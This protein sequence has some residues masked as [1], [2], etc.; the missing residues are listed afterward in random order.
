MVTDPDAGLGSG[1]CRVQVA[2]PTTRVDLALPTSV[3]VA[4]LLPAIVGYAEQDLAA[5]QG[6]ALSRL[7]GTRLDPAG[8]LAIA[9]IQEGE[10]LLLHAAHD[11]VGQPLY[12]DVVEVLSRTAPESGW[13]SRDTRLIGAGLGSLAVAGAVWAGITT[14]TRLAGILL[15]VLALLLLGAG[16]LLAHGTGDRG[17]GVTLA[18]LAALIGPVGGVLILGQPFGPAHLLVAAALLVFHAAITPPLIGGGDAVC[19]ALGLLGLLVILGGLLV[20][21][22]PATP[23]RAAAVVAPLAL[24]LTTVMPTLALRLSRI[25]RP[26]LP[27]TVAELAEVPGQL[28]LEQIQ[29][30]VDRARALL[31]GLLTGCYGAGTL[32]VIVLTTDIAT[33]WPA[34]LAALLG[35]LLLLRGRLFQRRAQVAAPLIAAAVIFV[36][37]VH[38]ATTI[39]ATNAAVLLG[40]IAPIALLLAVIAGGFGRWGGRTPL[41]PRLARG[42]DLLETM[43]LLAVVPIA[44]AVWN[45][46]TLLLELR[47]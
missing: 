25:P 47:A 2:A 45:V 32:A 31:T 43:L 11:R 20:V 33:P 38:A 17:A 19:L 46:Y 13:T 1:F 22:V 16:V 23:A 44:L 26:P 7:D 30:R 39:W 6:W 4:G 35:V 9:G 3:P 5:P 12:D 15:F 10:L 36:A 29:Q 41:N 14:G 37:G 24:A 27:R 18:T 21:L 8:G 42:F 28:E 40:V 34:V